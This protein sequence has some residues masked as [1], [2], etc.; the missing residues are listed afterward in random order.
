MLTTIFWY[1]FIGCGWATCFC[2]ISMMWVGIQREKIF[3]KICIT[4]LFFSVFTLIG[5]CGYVLTS[6]A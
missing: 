2:V 3:S 4:S 1:L 5:L 6:I